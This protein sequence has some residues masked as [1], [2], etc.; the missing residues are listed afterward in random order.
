MG[1]QVAARSE[2]RDPEKEEIE[3]AGVAGDP[4]RQGS[5]QTRMT[6]NSQGAP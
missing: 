2:E 4:C 5:L 1:E 6:G 3:R